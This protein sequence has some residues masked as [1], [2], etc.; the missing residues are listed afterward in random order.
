MITGNKWLQQSSQSQQSETESLTDLLA[1]NSSAEQQQPSLQTKRRCK[2]IYF[3][4]MSVF[5]AKLSKLQLHLAWLSSL[6]LV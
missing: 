5:N 3:L 1:G 6:L 4:I 2:M